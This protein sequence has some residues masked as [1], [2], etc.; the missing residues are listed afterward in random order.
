M[1]SVSDAKQKG[2]T[3]LAVVF[4]VV[5]M[6]FL[7]TAIVRIVMVDVTTHIAQSNAVK[8]FLIANAGLQ[9]GV[10]AVST[11][12]AS[13]HVSC[14]NLSTT[15]S[16]VSFAGGT[17]SVSGTLYLPGGISLSSGTNTTQTMIPVNTIT[18]L[19]PHGQI[20]IGSELI[21]YQSASTDSASCSGQNPCLLNA[22]R[23]ALGT[24]AT[25]HNGGDSISQNQCK[26]SSTGTIA[27]V[28]TFV[29]K[30]SVS[31]MVANHSAAWTA[32]YDDASGELIGRWN[33]QVWSRQA[34]S[35][36]IP[37]ETIHDIAVINN[38]DIW[39]VGDNRTFVHWNGTAWSTGTVDGSVPLVEI[40]GVDC[41]NTTDCWA[42]GKGGGSQ[43][44]LV[45]WNGTTWNITG[46]G[47]LSSKDMNDV[48]CVNSND[49]W[50]VGHDRTFIHWNGT[51]WSDGNVT[52]SGSDAVPN[53]E[54]FGVTCVSSSN[55]WAV[56]QPTSSIYT[57]IAHWNGGTW[58]RSTYN[59]A[60]F[61]ENLRKVACNSAS[62]CWI[63]GDLFFATPRLIHWNGSD[64]QN[65]SSSDMINV[66]LQNYRSVSCLSSQSCWAVGT[67]GAIIYWDGSNW[68]GSV[69]SNM[70]GS[71]ALNT[72]SV[73]SL[74]SL[75]EPT[76]VLS[77]WQQE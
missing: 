38:N 32:G 37:D 61:S 8:S 14:N 26:V 53:K 7:A 65:E 55:C 72:V 64:W 51:V 17:Y 66:P 41:I 58:T 33:G 68:S 57:N 16:N 18:G 62:D 76:K 13:A 25:T 19:A 24:V 47:S 59:N 44:T 36:N 45:H 60:R 31:N 50:A 75:S 48:S 74:A 28:G 54:Y 40:D 22:T 69:S 11:L 52:T 23:G 67:N 27:T 6:S 35:G 5:V 73:V 63:V 42:V 34:V 4:I 56:G 20:L 71:Q 10:Y 12:D 15:F 1:N 3:L 21:N 77:M 39:M 9:R 43:P 30:R 2:I 29:A 49:C 70:P 46:T